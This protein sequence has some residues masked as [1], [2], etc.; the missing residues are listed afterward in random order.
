METIILFLGE[1]SHLS[2]YKELCLCRV[3]RVDSAVL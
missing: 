2:S 1:T 3:Q